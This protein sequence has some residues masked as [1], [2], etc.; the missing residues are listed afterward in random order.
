MRQ[1]R[2]AD[3]HG[4]CGGPGTAGPGTA[5]FD[6]HIDMLSTSSSCDSEVEFDLHITIDACLACTLF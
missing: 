2:V 6:W 3:V 5:G 1:L 4:G